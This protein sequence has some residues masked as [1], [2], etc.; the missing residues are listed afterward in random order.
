MLR[1]A[2]SLRAHAMAASLAFG[3]FVL[4]A[5]AG[6]AGEQNAGYL[7]IVTSHGAIAGSSTDP[8]HQGWIPLR[9]AS[10]PS[11]SEITAT[12]ATIE[13]H[14]SQPARPSTKTAA[15]GSAS[16]ATSPRDA[17][18]G[19]PSGKRM[20]K[21]FTIVK[22]VDASSPALQKLAAS[23]EAIPEVWI[24]VR[25]TDNKQGAEQQFKLTDAIISSVQRSSGG[26]RPME[27]ISF[28]YEKIELVR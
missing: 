12:N 9:E 19:L 14:E 5:A 16:R 1:K 7:R 22:E 27:S 4:V 10:A 2:R 18:S 8:A 20:H 17:A 11:V 28:S 13:S 23:G 6:A 26:D 15:S 25:S 24:V 3:L 21:P